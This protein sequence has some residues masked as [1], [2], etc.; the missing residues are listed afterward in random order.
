[1]N[2][3][4]MERGGAGKLHIGLSSSFTASH[5][6]VTFLLCI[7]CVPL[8]FLAKNIIYNSLV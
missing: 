1:M 5:Q 3:W 4:S 6:N 7:L 8:H 2:W